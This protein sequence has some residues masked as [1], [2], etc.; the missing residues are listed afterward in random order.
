MRQL[1]HHAAKAAGHD[2]EDDEHKQL[3]AME[4][5]RVR[6]EKEAKA[7]SDAEAAKADAGRIRFR[8]SG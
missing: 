1:A 5:A 7:R 6:A 4:E 3:R 8:L 2:V